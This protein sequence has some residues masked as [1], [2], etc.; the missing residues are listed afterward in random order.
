MAMTET[1][2]TNASM[3]FL[4]TD[5]RH[6]TPAEEARARTTRTLYI[7]VHHPNDDYLRTSTSTLVLFSD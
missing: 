3:L 6:F 7:V 1:V 5:A 4:T 2:E